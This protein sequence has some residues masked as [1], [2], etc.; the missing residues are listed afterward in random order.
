MIAF[1]DTCVLYPMHLRDVLLRIGSDKGMFT[2]AWS[3]EVLA[4]LHRNL[5]PTI[6]QVSAGRL[7]TA[8][9]GPAF[10]D[11]EVIGFEHLIPTMTNHPKDRHVLAAAVWSEADMLVTAN[12]KDFPSNDPRVRVVHPDVFLLDFLRADPD[13]VIGVLEQ[14]VKDHRRDP[15]ELAALLEILGGS[16]VPGFAAEVGSRVGASG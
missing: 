13:T 9:R 3:P 7:L 6:G 8:L 16:G 2:P 1:L 10:A 4:E 15:K 12:L 5:V 11:S 14:R